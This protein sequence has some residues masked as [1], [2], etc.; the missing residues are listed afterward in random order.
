MN[1]RA[2]GARSPRRPG[3]SL[4]VA[5][6]VVRPERPGFGSRKTG[7]EVAKNR[8]FLSKTAVFVVDDTRLELVTSRTSSG[9]STS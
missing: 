4:S 7:V 3:F 1:N 6:S 8:Y 9:C 5:G 2:S